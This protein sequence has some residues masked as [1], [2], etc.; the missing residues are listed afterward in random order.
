MAHDPRAC[1]PG[2][3]TSLRCDW[4]TWCT[5]ECR[6]RFMSL[7][8]NSSSAWLFTAASYQYLIWIQSHCVCKDLPWIL[9]KKWPILPRL[10]ILLIW[11][12]LFMLWERYHT[13][14]HSTLLHRTLKTWN[15]GDCLAWASVGYFR[16]KRWYSDLAGGLQTLVNS[17]T[18]TR[19]CGK[20][21][22]FVNT[23]WRLPHP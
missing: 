23:I 5:M 22:R 3:K 1:G 10:V 6:A 11:M 13:C 2:H 20:H 18:G 4:K 14:P 21:G 16:W 19:A 17:Q 7:I 9:C 8:I 15:A 12:S